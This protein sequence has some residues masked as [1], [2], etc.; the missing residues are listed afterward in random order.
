[1]DF[2]MVECLAFHWA[3]S[4]VEKMDLLPVVRKD[5]NWVDR[6]VDVKDVRWG[7]WTEVLMVAS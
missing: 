5:E 3:D 6:S 7:V 4:T 1:M 2:L